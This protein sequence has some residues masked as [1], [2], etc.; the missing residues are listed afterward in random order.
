MTLEAL[1]YQDRKEA[2]LLTSTRW[3]TCF[4]FCVKNR[5]EKSI[6]TAVTFEK[7]LKLV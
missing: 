6:R 5:V 3:L 1:D 7:L 4:L 2:K